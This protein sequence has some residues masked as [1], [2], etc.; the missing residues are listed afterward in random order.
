MYAADYLDAPVALRLTIM[1]LTIIVEY[2]RNDLPTTLP[3]RFC[4]A[5]FY[6]RT[7]SRGRKQKQGGSQPTHQKKGTHFAQHELI[8][9]HL[10]PH[11][12]S[13]GCASIAGRNKRKK[14]VKPKALGRRSPPRASSAH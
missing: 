10:L 7:T 2:F 14:T 6:G 3:S 9:T 11:G 5:P 12:H 13:T 1:M 8:L 4:H